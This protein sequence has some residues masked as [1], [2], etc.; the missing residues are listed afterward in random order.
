MLTLVAVAFRTTCAHPA[1]ESHA[2]VVSC[3]AQPEPSGVGPSHSALTPNSVD[4]ALDS[5]AEWFVSDAEPLG[6][7]I[8]I[9]L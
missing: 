4:F 7:V 6:V 8:D 1:I 5:T 9:S 2:G 3:A